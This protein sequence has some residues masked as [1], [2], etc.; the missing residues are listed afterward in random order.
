VAALEDVLELY[1]APY[2]PQRPRLGFDERPPPLIAE[3]RASLAAEPGTP[4]RY[5]TASERRGVGDLMRSG[6]PKRGF[7]QGD[8]TDRRTPL[9]CAHRMKHSADL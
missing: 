5:D 6:E 3:V 8:L 1:E 9:A 2:N 4:A 7:R